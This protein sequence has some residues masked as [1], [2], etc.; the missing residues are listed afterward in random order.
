MKFLFI[1]ASHRRGGAEI[2]FVTLAR[3]L[4]SSG[5]TVEAVVYPDAPVAE[6]LA[7]SAVPLH[8]A[9]FRNAVDPRGFWRTMTAARRLQPDWLVGG[10]GK[11]HLATVAVGRSL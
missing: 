10:T 3:A 5:H 8:F 4:A 7:G 11:E 9:C 6:L 1:A 2:Q